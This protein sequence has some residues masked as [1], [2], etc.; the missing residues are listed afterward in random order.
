MD[1]WFLQNSLNHYMLII[2][3]N[4]IY[5]CLFHLSSNCVVKGEG[6][7]LNGTDRALQLKV[8]WDT[9]IFWRNDFVWCITFDIVNQACS[10]SSLVEF[11]SSRFIKNKIR[12]VKKIIDSVSYYMYLLQVYSKTTGRTHYVQ[13]PTKEGYQL[14]LDFRSTLQKGKK[15]QVYFICTCI[16]FI[17]KTTPDKHIKICD[18][19][20]NVDEPVELLVLPGVWR[21]LDS[22]Q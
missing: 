5:N 6:Q 2:L 13:I 15:N 18:L 9:S 20:E 12:K 8:V 21:T 17:Y 19:C 3:L 11:W 10:Q 1:K 14:S 22:D 4:R 7:M 16:M